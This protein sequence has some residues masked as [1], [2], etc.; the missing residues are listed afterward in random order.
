MSYDTET[1]LSAALHDVV[2]DRP[3]TPDIDQ[4]EDRGR[5][6]RHRRTAWRATAA[7]GFAIAAVTAVAVAAGGSGVQAPA[8]T[9][10]GP[11]PTTPSTSAPTSVKSDPAPLL[12]LV[13]YL[14]TAEQSRGDAT[15]YLRHQ[16]YV[17]GPTVDDHDLYADN[18]DYFYAGTKAGLPAR[19]RDHHTDG[20]DL[21]R[22][23]IT[24]AKYAANGDLKEARK[25]MASAPS[26][27]TKVTD[28]GPG[29]V[30]SAGDYAG[31]SPEVVQGAQVNLTDNWIWTDSLDALQAGGGN[32]K[33]RAG[34]L[35]ILANMPEVK[36]ASGTAAGRPTISLTAGSPAL[37]GDEVETL[38]IDA[39]TGLPIKF[40]NDTGDTITYTATRVN[41]A[42]V[43][44]GSF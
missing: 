29:V 38:T 6:L 5:T 9:V 22:R 26:P 27:S 43:A 32:P 10:A 34:V 15:L 18:G 24:A 40:T 1:R 16:V 2:G 12:R 33:V 17:G 41:L 39:K 37:A 8:H 25:R 44:K 19:V 3:F 11:K 23:E 20:G 28:I 14:Q 21:W 42:D 36:I 13:S 30:P 4:I 31:L 35:R 7:G